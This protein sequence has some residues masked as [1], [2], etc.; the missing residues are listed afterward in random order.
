MNDDDEVVSEIPVY[1]THNLNSLYLLQSPLR[2]YSRSYATDYGAPQM[3]QIKPIQRRIDMIYNMRTEQ[4]DSNSN[5]SQS[6]EER[7]LNEK[8][9]YHFDQYALNSTNKL[10]VTGRCVPAKTNYAVGLLRNGQLHLTPLHAICRLKPNLE[11]IDESD[12]KE[13]EKDAE[14]EDEDASAE[15]QSESHSETNTTNS[16]QGEG[17]PSYTSKNNNSTSTSSP[18]SSASLSRVINDENEASITLRYHLP[19]SIV[20][21][22]ELE[23]L[24]G[25]NAVPL[26]F[27]VQA[28]DY[29]THINGNLL[30]SSSLSASTVPAPLVKDLRYNMLEQCFL[31]LRSARIVSIAQCCERLQIELHQQYKL[32]ELRSALDRLCHVIQDCFVLRSMYVFDRFWLQWQ[33]NGTG[34]FPAV[35]NNRDRTVLTRAEVSRDYLLSKFYYKS[36][37]SRAEATS[38]MKLNLE[39][40]EDRL[41]ELSVLERQVGPDGQ[42]QSWWRWRV[43]GN[44]EISATIWREKSWSELKTESKSQIRELEKRAILLTSSSSTLS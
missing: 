10:H 1:L 33:T 26:N 43:D 24:V 34:N 44:D 18:P 35:S 5:S 9:D 39:M 19:N 7:I 25:E 3:V 11:Y 41:K 36:T 32:T 20:A 29:L 15:P 2:P 42:I 16:A 4:K 14:M 21:L 6:E 28:K 27:H 12:E 40:T 37:L 8:R 22:T 13:K 23:K 31:L 38:V 30:P 17:K